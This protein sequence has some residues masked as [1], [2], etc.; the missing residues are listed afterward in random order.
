MANVKISSKILRDVTTHALSPSLFKTWIMTACVLARVGGDTAALKESQIA[1]H[2][3]MP[4][5]KFIKQIA[6]LSKLD[7]VFISP[8]GEI[9]IDRDDLICCQQ[10]ED[11]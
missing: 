3:H 11:Q 6:K 10:D 7:L 8:T 5:K 1:F 4:K 2:L 9:S